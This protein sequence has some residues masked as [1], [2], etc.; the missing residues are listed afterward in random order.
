MKLWVIY[1][2]SANY[3]GYGEHCVVKAETED[4][5]R[6]VASGY[7]EDFYYEQD[8]DQ[9]YEDYA[10]EDPEYWADIKTV[11]LFDETHE[12]WKYF[13]DPKQSSFYPLIN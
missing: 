13:K 10:E 9:Y 4:E 2:E 6:E 3:C 12:S 7:A 11:E 5:A 8:S 1:F